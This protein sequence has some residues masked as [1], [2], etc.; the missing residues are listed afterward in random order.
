MRLRIAVT[1]LEHFRDRGD[2]VRCGGRARV[3]RSV[4]VEAGVYVE[5][6]AGY[7]GGLAGE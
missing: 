2:G 3:R 7:V 4:H 6:L 1:Q 5:S